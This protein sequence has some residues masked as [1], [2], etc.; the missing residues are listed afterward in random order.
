MN[1]S[2]RTLLKTTGAAV[3]ATPFLT[4]AAA[5]S[6]NLPFGPVRQ[7]DAG[8]LNVGY[9][10]LGPATGTPVLL[11]HGF[12]YDIHSF[13]EVGP[14][15]ARRGYRVVIPYLR[16]HGSTTF[17]S[18]A[19]PRNV[20]QAAFALD[21]LALMDALHIRRAVLA[22]YDWGSRTADI[23]AALWPER[24]QALVSV[25]GYLITNLEFNKKPLPPA[26]E[27]AWWYQYYFTT[28]RGV[29]GLHEYKREL[30]EFIW[31][32][33][34]P[35]W[36]YSATTYAR[37]AAAFDNPDYE[38]IVIGNYRWRQSLV[39]AEPEYAEL[40]AVLQ[41]TP[42]IA[43]PT[44]TIDGKYD[45]FTPAGNGSSYRDHFVGRYEHRTFDVGHNVPQEAPREFAR[46]VVDV[47]R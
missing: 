35:T 3:A 46:A 43:V 28:E 39:P 7:I 10:E 19:T 33:N 14:L 13:E 11:L 29:Q 30:G 15:L 47:S 25:T 6:P 34:S 1:I 12:P 18:A 4:G 2:R 36:K 44:I 23:I 20:D 42:K 32:F 26:A 24:V 31:K 8:V 45:P 21:I 17:R 27:N 16:G 41:K 5:A 37:T 22:G 38:A 9:V 40:E